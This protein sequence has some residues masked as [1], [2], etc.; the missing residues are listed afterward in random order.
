MRSGGRSSV[1]AIAVSRSTVRLAVTVGAHGAGVAAR[2]S[3]WVRTSTPLAAA[4]RSIASRPS[5]ITSTAATGSKPS[6]AAVTARTRCPRPSR[7]ARPRRRARAAARGTAGWSGGRR[8]RTAAPGSITT[9]SSPPV[10]GGGQPRRPDAEPARR[11]RDLDRLQVV[12]P[13]AL[14]AGRH[15]GQRDVD[16]RVAHERAHIVELGSSARGA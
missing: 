15:V 3:Q 9:S 7:T 1:S 8:R 2:L 4:L 6:R 10:A 5:G 16:Q 12:V 11:R 13:A 14:P